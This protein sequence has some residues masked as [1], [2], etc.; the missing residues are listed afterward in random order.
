MPRTLPKIVALTLAE[1]KN[2]TTTQ[3]P[4]SLSLIIAS[5][6]KVSSAAKAARRQND[7]ESDLGESFRRWVVPGGITRKDMRVKGRWRQR[8]NRG[9][10]R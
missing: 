5:L 1:N 4:L 3:M 2:K 7:W 8:A 6:G 10:V 9:A